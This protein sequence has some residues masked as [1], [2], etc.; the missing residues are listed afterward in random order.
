MY[1][2]TFHWLLLSMCDFERTRERIKKIVSPMFLSRSPLLFARELIEF[3]P[4]GLSRVFRE[5][6]LED[7]QLIHERIAGQRSKRKCLLHLYPCL[8]FHSSISFSFMSFEVFPILFFRQFRMVWEM[9]KSVYSSM[10]GPHKKGN[11]T[12]I[13]IGHIFPSI[14]AFR[15]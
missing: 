9:A 4:F 5:H 6:W 7:H 8:N 13:S 15:R 12:Y 10:H 2:E 14:V 3:R 11:T 1:K